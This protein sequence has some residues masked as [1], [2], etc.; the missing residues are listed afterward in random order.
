MSIG[1][2][3]ACLP[4]T[5][6]F[7]WVLVGQ[8][9]GRFVILGEVK[10]HEQVGCGHAFSKILFKQSSAVPLQAKRALNKKTKLGF[11]VVWRDGQHLAQ[12]CLAGMQFRNG[13]I[14]EEAGKLLE[15]RVWLGEFLVLHRALQDLAVGACQRTCSTRLQK[16]GSQS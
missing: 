16:C 11:Y 2:G 5:Q 6:V 14:K 1:G 7:H 9:H 8:R 13:D 15:V 10:V 3:Q 12:D 4:P